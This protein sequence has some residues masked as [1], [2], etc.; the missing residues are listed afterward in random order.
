MSDVGVYSYIIF[1]QK[2]IALKT[3]YKVNTI[4]TGSCKAIV[5]D[6]NQLSFKLGITK[7]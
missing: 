2:R 7:H 6:K 5:E 3:N 1:S 4:I